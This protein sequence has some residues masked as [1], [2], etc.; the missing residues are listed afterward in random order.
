MTEF[1]VF[2]WNYS[3]LTGMGVSPDRERIR[4]MVVLLHG[5][6]GDAE[7]NMSF[8]SKICEACPQCVV[9]VPDGPELV[10]VVNDPHH[11]QWYPLE[12]TADSDG[13][14]YA[15]MPYYAPPEKQQKIRESTPRIQKTAALL[16]RFVL[17]Q[18]QA[19]DLTLHDCFLSGISQ[20]GITAYDMVLFRRELWGN[21]SDDFLGGLIIIGAGIHESDR[22]NGLRIGSIPKIPVL[23]A[24]GKLDE[25]F[26]PTVDYFSAAQLRL[27]KLSVEI[28]QADSV[29]F[30]LEHKVCDAVCHFIRQ[31]S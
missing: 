14:L 21:G 9:L 8:A 18:L 24:R 22:L 11:R 12:E 28:S 10:P 7:S 31:K 20:G 17:D 26:P 27:H 3:G 2:S 13:Y 6:M 19:Y 15:A 4:K 16:N 1:K 23:L 25:I 29:H 30:G 5:Y